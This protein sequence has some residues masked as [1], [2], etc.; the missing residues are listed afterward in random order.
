MLDRRTD[1]SSAPVKMFGA[2][3]RVR[4]WGFHDV[5]KRFQRLEVS[6]PPRASHVAQQFALGGKMQQPKNLTTI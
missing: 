3:R 6:L 4:F 5:S 1:V 2:I